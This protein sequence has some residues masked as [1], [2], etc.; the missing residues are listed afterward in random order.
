MGEQ[1]YLDGPTSNISIPF[2]EQAI[3]PAAQP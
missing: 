2:L 3:Q 1:S